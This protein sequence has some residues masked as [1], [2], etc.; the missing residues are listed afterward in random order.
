MMMSN[1]KKNTLSM[2][3]IKMHIFCYL[4]M[5]PAVITFL[6][7][8]VYINFSSIAM[9]FQVMKPDGSYNWGNGAFEWGLGNF[10]YFFKELS[11]GDSMFNEAIR[12]SLIFFVCNTFL[13][14]P[15]A[16]IFCYFVYK[17]I[18][19]YNT[20]RV[21]IYLP[22]IVIGTVTSALFKQVIALNG[23]IAVFISHFGLEMPALF[24]TTETAM[25]SLVFYNFFYGIGGNFILLG[26]AMNAIPEETL[27]AAKIDGCSWFREMVQLVIPMCWPTLSTMLITAAAGLFSSSGPI[28]LFTKG[29]Y[30]TYTI[31]YWMYEQLLSG[32]NLEISS[33][34]G[35]VF[36]IIALPI[37]LSFKRL[38]FWIDD[39]IG[40]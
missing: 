21:L 12:N 27:E 33:A 6:V 13:D 25:P 15:F 38:M 28:L 7:W 4:M 31:S 26:G 40:V 22:N 8:Y 10:S 20:L 18:L 2:R 1:K 36:T 34:I 17:K 14:L 29:A 32:T 30:G 19:G 3:S 39:K 16:L 11:L 37:V 35:I 5:V 9:A 24:N 23:P